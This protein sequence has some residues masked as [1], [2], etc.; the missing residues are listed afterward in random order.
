MISGSQKARMYALSGVLRSGAGRSGYIPPRAFITIGGVPAGGDNDPHVL[1]AGIR[2]H[3][4]QNEVPNTAMFTVHGAR[5]VAGAEVLIRAGTKNGPL[6]FAG[7]AIRVT[8]RYAVQNP[9]NILYDVEC[10]DYGWLLNGRTVTAQYRSMSASA[11]ARALVS[12]WAPPGFSAA[13]IV[14]G[15]PLLE[16][17]TFTDVPLMDALTRLA[18]RVGGYASVDYQKVIGLWLNDPAPTPSALTPGNPTLLSVSAVRDYSRVVTRAYVVGGGASAATPAAPGDASIVV[19]DPSWYNGAGGW[20]RIGPQRVRY[21][22]V[23]GAAGGGSMVG[24]GAAPSVAM[25]GAAT[26]QAGAGLG[27]G[28]YSY[29]YSWVTA[30][31]ETR[32][33]PVAALNAPGLLPAPTAALVSV[34]HDTTQGVSPNHAIGFSIGA[35]VQFAYV[36]KTGTMSNLTA[37]E[38][39]SLEGPPIQTV[40]QRFGSASSEAVAV[41]VGVFPARPV[42]S[43]SWCNFA[44][45]VV[46]T[47]NGSVWSGWYECG[48]SCQYFGLATEEASTKTAPMYGPA[49]GNAPTVPWASRTGINAMQLS[50]IAAGPAAVTQ[51][52]VY[53]SVA[54]GTTRVLV[55][56]IADNVTTTYLDVV[57][58]SALSGRPGEPGGDTS[59]IG[60]PQGQVNAGSPTLPVASASPFTVA[61]GWVKVGGSQFVRYTGVSGNTLTGIPAAGA[62]ALVASVQFGSAV[63]VVVALTGIPASGAGAI[64]SAIAAGDQVNVLAIVTDND[65]VAALA[66]ARGGDGI[67][68]AT[69]TDQRISERE[70]FSQAAALIAQRKTAIVTVRYRSRDPLTRSG[71][72]VTVN[73]PAPTDYSATVKIQ[74]V[75]ISWMGTTGRPVYDAVASSDRYT[76]DDLLRQVRG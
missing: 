69:L 31:G 35:S 33:G 72:T 1:H 53:R 71:P 15:L 54:N 49:S 20:L 59:A 60:Q 76:F 4:Q 10:T 39:F 3:D 61:G 65:A 48:G 5:P 47:W 40:L 62:G 46:R 16:D 23:N 50:G 37:G 56:T 70:A 38:V 64:R 68:E 11:I 63:M 14:D 26:V 51:R 73:I 57:A 58:D 8:Q 66:A 13:N 34:W 17:I 36:Y 41:P 19:E 21:T 52:K 43:A 42:G 18:N 45:P 2:I 28:L 25:T 75:T 74:D 12:E 67:A 22:G 44:V 29:T 30:T 27:A 55:V 9:I 32:V 7:H 6:M 24:P